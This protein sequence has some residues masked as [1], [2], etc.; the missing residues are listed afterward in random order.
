MNKFLFASIAVLC[1]ILSSCSTQEYDF[2]DPQ[3]DEITKTV[4]HQVD[5]QVSS[6]S[7]NPLTVYF[8]NTNGASQS[9]SCEEARLTYISRTRIEVFIT[10]ADGST[11]T[12]LG[13]DVDIV[14][15]SGNILVTIDPSNSFTTTELQVETCIPECCYSDN[16]GNNVGTALS[17]IV[18]DEPAGF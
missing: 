6:R 4:D 14:P 17:F 7:A 11:Q 3:T 16:S 1:T 8:T 2:T 9:I 10:Y 13:N 5:H 12:E 15:N 18:E